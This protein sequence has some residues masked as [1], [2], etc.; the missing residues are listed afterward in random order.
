MTAGAESTLKNLGFFA[1]DAQRLRVHEFGTIHPSPVLVFEA[2]TP[3]SGEQSFSTVRS[4]PNE[5]SV[6]TVARLAKRD[7]AN[8]FASMITIGRAP[9]N[10]IVIPAAAVSKFHAFIMLIGSGDPHLL[11]DAGSSNGTSVN[12]KQLEARTER[13]K[14]E[15]GAEVK[16]GTL[17]AVFYTSARFYEALR[18]GTIVPSRT[19]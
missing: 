19:P 12:G 7:G 10:D 16:L 2:F 4:E 14:L 3:D 8:A 6:M 13:A 17:R 1:Q 5:G 11:V 18:T 15:S 9:N